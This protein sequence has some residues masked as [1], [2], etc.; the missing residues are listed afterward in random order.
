MED[1]TAPVPADQAQVGNSDASTQ[2]EGGYHLPIAN[3]TRIMRKAIP[4]HAKISKE[5]KDVVQEC[6]T[7]FLL[8]ITSEYVAFELV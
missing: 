5:A 1:T 8:F 2:R 6:V 7:E 3:I 4:R